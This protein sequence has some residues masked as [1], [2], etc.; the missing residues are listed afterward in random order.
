MHDLI[1]ARG[2]HRPVAANP[3]LRQVRQSVRF[4]DSQVAVER[5]RSL[6]ADRQR[7]RSAPLA[8]HPDHPLVQVD[9]VDGHAG[10][11]GTAS[12]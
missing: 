12:V 6:A 7:P 10:A 11:L 4:P 5:L 8:E 3:D 9:V 1:D 2:S